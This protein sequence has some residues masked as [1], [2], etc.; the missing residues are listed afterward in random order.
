MEYRRNRIEQEQ[1]WLIPEFHD[2]VQG[3]TPEEIDQSIED[4]KLRSASVIENFRAA[5]ADAR[6]PVRGASPTGQ[7]SMGGPLE[8]QPNIEQLSVE[9]IKKMDNQTYSRYR[10]RLMQY[11]RRG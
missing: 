9:D 7:P 1:Q 11:T 8:Q 4:M 5:Y 10:D 6:P 2:L 3:T